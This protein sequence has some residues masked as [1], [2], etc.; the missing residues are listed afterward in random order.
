MDQA[1]LSAPQWASVGGYCSFLPYVSVRCLCA[2]MTNRSELLKSY[3]RYCCS[4]L[5]PHF[6]SQPG[7]QSREG[8][9]ARQK[10]QA[11]VSC[12]TAPLNCKEGCLAVKRPLSNYRSTGHSGDEGILSEKEKLARK[13]KTVKLEVWHLCYWLPYFAHF[14]NTNLQLT[15]WLLLV[16]LSLATVRQMKLRGNDFIFYLSFFLKE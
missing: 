9:G 1:A 16:P 12:E 15:P 8:E 6:C 7:L 10:D 11:G 2:R 14:F 13:R 4:A 5:L 3:G